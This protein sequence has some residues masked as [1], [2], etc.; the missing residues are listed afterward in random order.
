[1]KLEKTEFFNTWTAGDLRILKDKADKGFYP[2]QLQKRQG[3][4]WVK[5]RGFHSLAEAKKAAA[6]M[7]EDA[8]MERRA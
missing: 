4:C 1:M 2:Y 3:G 8:E 6:W 7:A 5:V